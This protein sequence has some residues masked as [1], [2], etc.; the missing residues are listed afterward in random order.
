MNEL[1]CLGIIFA[2]AMIIYGVI[3]IGGKL[4]PDI[5]SFIRWHS[6]RKRDLFSD[7]D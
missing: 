2:S 3:S 1:I 5:K 7:E 6:I 4:L